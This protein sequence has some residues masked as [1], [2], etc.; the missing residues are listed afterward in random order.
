MERTMRDPP[1]TS[2]ELA[3]LDLDNTTDLDS[4]QRHFGFKPMALHQGLGYIKPS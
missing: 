4:V 3:Q 2:V 1:A